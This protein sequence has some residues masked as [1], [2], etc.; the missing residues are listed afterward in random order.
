MFSLGPSSFIV[1]GVPN[2]LG[3]HDPIPKIMPDTSP[4]C[5]NHS[6]IKDANHP[7]THPFLIGTHPSRSAASLIPRVAVTA[8]T[9]PSGASP[10]VRRLVGLVISSPRRIEEDDLQGSDRVLTL[11][12]G[13][14]S[15]IYEASF[16]IFYLSR[17]SL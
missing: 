5:N 14:S 8:S 6:E 13:V 12:T 15:A 9:P 7:S 1:L 10:V 4:M 2:Y 11:I 16:V 3:G 17:A